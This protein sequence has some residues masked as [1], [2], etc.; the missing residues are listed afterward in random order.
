[1]DE[2]FMDKKFTH[3]KTMD[4]ESSTWM[5]IFEKCKLVNVM[6]SLNS[7][8]NSKFLT[9]EL[10]FSHHAPFFLPIEGCPFL[11]LCCCNS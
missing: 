4:D 1:M 11:F 7:M 8:K 10:H 2:I 9:M 6:N 5:K 3:P